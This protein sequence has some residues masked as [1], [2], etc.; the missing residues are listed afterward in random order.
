MNTPTFRKDSL[1]TLVI[2]GIGAILIT[3]LL[4][5]AGAF[6]LIERMS[7][8]FEYIVEHPLREINE[9]I[10]L[11]RLAVRTVIS[12]DHYLIHNGAVDRQ[13]F[14]ESDRQL[15]S[16]F[17]EKL[18]LTTLFPEQRELLQSAADEWNKARKFIRPLLTRSAPQM[19]PSKLAVIG[20][21]RMDAHTH[22]ML[23]LLHRL[24]DITFEEVTEAEEHAI[25]IKDRVLA[26]FTVTLTIMLV[27]AGASSVFL[28]RGIFRP[29]RHLE[30]SVNILAAGDL[31]HR[32]VLSTPVELG[33]L[34]ER[35][36]AMAEELER[37][38][39]ALKDLSIH[40]ALTGAINRRE[41][42]N[43]LLQ[44]VALAQ[45]HGESFTLLMLDI[46]HFKQVNDSFGHQAGDDVLRALSS[47]IRDKL[48]CSEPLARYGGEEFA[49]IL[50]KT[51]SRR[52][53]AVAER[54][55][56]SIAEYNAFIA[57]GKPLRITVS[58][59]LARFPGDAD[60]ET[61]L[62]SAADKAL[63]AAKKSGRNRVSIYAEN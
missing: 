52:G 50:P 13:R 11:E 49:V 7:S 44:E 51:D 31:S 57:N 19:E 1:K 17:A 23:D 45:R 28:T 16:V 29:L 34:A 20:I 38:H 25:A 46:D 41:F 3:A 37:N 6:W 36:N 22:R 55:R 59:G 62:I 35:F 10:E 30:Q 8:T 12:A 60:S 27:V 54:L 18:A 4:I 56:Q 40:D 39:T 48:R 2:T 21:E 5:S 53:L 42:R 61:K 63:Y 47:L 15:T 58:I 9:V 24:H 32:V 33:R 43:R 14:A 26:L